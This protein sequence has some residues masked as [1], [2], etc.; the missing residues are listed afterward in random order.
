LPL[1]IE[2][3]LSNRLPVRVSGNRAQRPLTG[4]RDTG[5]S[6]FVAVPEVL[7][8][9]ARTGRT[10]TAI[11][12]S[13]KEGRCLICARERKVYFDTLEVRPG[14]GPRNITAAGSFPDVVAPSA[15]TCR[16][17]GSPDVSFR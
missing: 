15:T 6:C 14:Q 11:P 5:C 13:S 10:A 9:V 4:C 7:S 2:R 1:F 12:A 3:E 8:M 16:G 17:F